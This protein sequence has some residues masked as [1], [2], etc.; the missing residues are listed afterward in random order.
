MTAETQVVIARPAAPA[1][2]RAMR[3]YQ[4]PKNAI[5][6][7]ALVFSTGEAWHPSDA[8]SWWPALWRSCAL[9]V[10][11]CMASSAIYLCNDVRDRENDRMHPRKCTRP[12]AA[13]EVTPATAISAAIV[14]LVAAIPLTFALGPIA[15]GVLAA[16]VV[17]MTGY[18]MGLKSVP[19]LDVLIL[20]GGVVARAVAGAGA[21]DV[22]ISPWLY[23]CSSLGAFFFASTKRWAE[24][25]QLGGA[26][27]AHRPSLAHYDA[28]LLGR[29]VMVSAAGTLISYVIYT[30]ESAHV[31]GNGAMALTVPFVAFG[32]LRYLMLIRGVRQGDAPDRILFTDMPIIGSM[33]CF[34]AVA[35]GVLIVR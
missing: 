31:P 22:T 14:L 2:L 24:Y 23:I 20:C 26:A 12:I 19:I 29:M 33:L 18:S 25:R 3:P 9:F 13:G 34:V 35:L 5:V 27:A 8:G 15:G 10:L 21:I 6:F 32:M 30:I 7:A 1:L 16:Y 4:W 17:V 28:E 11:W